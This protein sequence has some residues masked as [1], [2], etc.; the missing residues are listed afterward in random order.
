MIG[1][2][3]FKRKGFDVTQTHAHTHTETHADLGA[4]ILSTLMYIV[5]GMRDNVWQVFVPSCG[6]NT[7]FWSLQHLQA[8]HGQTFR[9]ATDSEN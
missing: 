2:C 6:S 9:M 3:N 7:F 5:S 1:S 4:H 8:G